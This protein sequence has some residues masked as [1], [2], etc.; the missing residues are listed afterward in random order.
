MTSGGGDGGRAPRWWWAGRGARSLFDLLGRWSRP[1]AL[2]GAGL[3]ASIGSGIASGGCAEL[4][5]ETQAD[6]VGS[7]LDQQQA[8]GWNVG[9]EDQPLT[10]P[11]AQENDISGSASWRDD[12]IP[13]ALR[14][15]PAGARW[16]PFYN[17]TLFQSL[18]APRNADL[19]VLIR[20]IYTQATALA[21]RR[22]EALLSLLM[23][24]DHCR[25]DVGVVL[26]LDGPEA[27][28]VA[29][30]LAPCLDPVFVFANWPHPAGVVP[31]HLTLGSVL[32]FLPAFQRGRAARLAGAPPAFVLDRRRLAPYADD[33]DEFDNRYTVGLPPP[34]ALRAAGIARL[35]YVTPDDQVTMESDDLNDDLVA[36]AH[37][38]VDVRLLALSDFSQRPLPDWPAS[39]P[40][41]PLA[42]PFQT[43]GERP[44][45]FGGSPEAQSCFAYWYGWIPWPPVPPTDGA[46]PLFTGLAVSPPPPIPPHLAP[47]CHFHPAPRVVFGGLAG[48]PP[49]GSRPAGVGFHGSPPGG[50]RSGSMG[51]F[52]GGG[53]FG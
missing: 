10:F 12:S 41:A 3:G 53:F 19:H 37:H 18:D 26:D 39:S 51:R 15:G 9:S 52:H 13:L 7:A 35:L 17:P 46:L 8:S 28:A 50:G 24:G 47:R 33:A 21:Y 16:Q 5:E 25:G 23:D 44:F 14:L 38:G 27:V 48:H 40:C 20:P 34:E 2:G 42:A 43:P 49:G 30:A 4:I 22:G 32:Y 11:G 1:L 45:F 31:A 36:A 6:D 29:A